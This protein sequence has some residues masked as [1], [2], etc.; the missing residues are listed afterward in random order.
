MIVRSNKDYLEYALLEFLFVY[1]LELVYAAI[2]S[3][4][5][6]ILTTRTRTKQTKDAHVG[7]LVGA[8]LHTTIY[9]PAT[10]SACPAKRTSS[11]GVKTGAMVPSAPLSLDAFSE[12]F[13]VA[14]LVQND[15]LA[16]RTGQELSSWA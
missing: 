15:W 14:T 4:I 13:A 16:T 9:T 3:C 12:L 10:T 7:A 6:F 1:C 8:I 11:A 5:P 2:A